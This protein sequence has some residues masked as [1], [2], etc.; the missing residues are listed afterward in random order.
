MFGIE[1]QASLLAELQTMVDSAS[2]RS[3]PSQPFHQLSDG[4]GEAEYGGECCC[5]ES[6]LFPSYQAH[7][8]LL[9]R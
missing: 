9:P 1:S 2:S 6:D 7:A 4:I 3:Q 8:N 5:P